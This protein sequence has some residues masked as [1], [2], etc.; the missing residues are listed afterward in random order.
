VE[1]DR[2]FLESITP[3]DEDERAAFEVVLRET[4]EPILGVETRLEVR[5]Y[6]HQVWDEGS[7]PLVLGSGV[8]PRAYDCCE[9]FPFDLRVTTGFAI[10]PLFG[11]G[12]QLSLARADDGSWR[13]METEIWQS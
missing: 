11:H 2:L 13:V 7:L 3:R 4:G 12:H 9:V 8:E 10:G 6:V 1:L 5:R